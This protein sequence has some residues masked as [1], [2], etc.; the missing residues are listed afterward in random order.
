MS[1]TKKHFNALANELRSARKLVNAD[2]IHGFDEAV[3]AVIAF[4]RTQNPAFDA[5]HFRN[6][7]YNTD[8]E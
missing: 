2:N 4:C 5:Q 1:M 7:V 8:K 3:D 6:V